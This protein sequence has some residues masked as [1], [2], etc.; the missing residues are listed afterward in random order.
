MLDLV[1][2]GIILVAAIYGFRLGLM[3]SLIGLL[4]NLIALFLGYTLAKPTAEWIQLQFQ[5]GDTLAEYIK[6]ILPMPEDFSEMVASMDGL[7]KLYSY[8]ESSPLPRALQENIL[9]NVQI[10]INAMDQ[11]AFLTMADTVAQTVAQGLLQGLCFI[12]LWLIFCLC[13][14]FLGKI[15]VGFIHHIPVIGFLDRLGGLAVTVFLVVLTITVLYSGICI[16]GLG[17][18]GILAE[19]ELLG[20]LSRQLLA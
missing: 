3:K 7:G 8:L 15:F 10:Q 19:S 1:L 18:E 16:L 4:G 20:F 9:T 13:L 5:T 2:L 6:K 14:T 12:G 11:G 17:E